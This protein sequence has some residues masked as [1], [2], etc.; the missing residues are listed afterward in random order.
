[1]WSCLNGLMMER[2]NGLLEGTLNG[3]TTLA[4]GLALYLIQVVDSAWTLVVV[5][6]FVAVEFSVDAKTGERTAISSVNENTHRLF[7]IRKR[8][9][10][11]I[12]EDGGRVKIHFILGFR[13]R[14]AF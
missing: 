12:W 3:G 11:P 10:H 7:S 14:R 2:D 9:I 5:V 4:I 8:G 1:M 6:V 13:N